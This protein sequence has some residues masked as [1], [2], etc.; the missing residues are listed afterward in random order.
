MQRYKVAIQYLGTRYH[1]WQRNQQATCV[2]VQDVLEKAIQEFVGPDNHSPCFISS[3]TDAGV[4]AIR[5]VLL[6]DL[7][8][9]ARQVG[10]V[11]EPHPPETV[12]RAL[13]AF[14]KDNDVRVLDVAAV[15]H[16][17]PEGFHARFCAKERRYVYRLVTG[18]SAFET[19]R[20]WCIGHE[21]DVDAMRTAARVLVGKKLD[22]SSF[23][24]A[25]CQAKS[26]VKT[27]YEI[28]VVRARREL[29]QPPAYGEVIHVRVRAPS[30]LY[31][32]H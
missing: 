20:A 9:R 2:A 31:H 29:P 16:E 27:L 26:P 32:H 30:F 8:R 28:E 11:L 15:P 17:G 24:G 14:L 3:R 12:G 23:R 4:H 1:G 5:N 6:V 7:C 18:H 21:L 10:E 19:N 13:N 25:D 22:F